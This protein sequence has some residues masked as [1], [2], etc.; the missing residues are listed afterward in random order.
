[1]MSPS[2][3]CSAADIA[4]GSSRTGTVRA[5]GRARQRGLQVPEGSAAP[6]AVL[7]P[8]WSPQTMEL[9][10]GLVADVTHMPH[11]ARGW[12]VAFRYPE[13]TLAHQ[14]QTTSCAAKPGVQPA[15]D[16]RSSA[17]GKFRRP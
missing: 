9:I 5:V 12:P 4:S 13:R 14:R 11:C 15:M 1:M 7:K 2:S 8:E 17:P 16:A 6:A 3:E 10:D